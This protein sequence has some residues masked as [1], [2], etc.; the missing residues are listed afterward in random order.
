MEEHHRLRAIIAVEVEARVP[1]VVQ[2]SALQHQEA[3]EA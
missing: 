1:Q 2:V 3:L